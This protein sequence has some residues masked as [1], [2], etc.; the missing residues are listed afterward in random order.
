AYNW[1]VQTV[2]DANDL[3]AIENAIKAA[4]S[5]PRPSIICVKSVIGYG[6]PNK[7]GTAKGHGEPLG[8]EAVKLTQQ[9]LGWRYEGPVTVPEKALNNFR[10]AIAR[11]RKV[12]DEWNAKSESYAKAYPELAAEWRQWASGKLPEGWQSAAPVFPPDKP[13]ATREASGKA[14]NAFAK[15]LPMLIGGSPALRPSDNTFLSGQG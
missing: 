2:A 14:L 4:Q 11:G 6:S 15:V 12:E 8:A 7:A 9:N 13:M 10:Q 1:H 3:V 5:D